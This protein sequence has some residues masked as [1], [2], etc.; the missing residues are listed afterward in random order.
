MGPTELAIDKLL[1]V[2]F[3]LLLIGRLLVLLI[4][5]EF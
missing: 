1:M 5:G 3:M 2:G 4:I